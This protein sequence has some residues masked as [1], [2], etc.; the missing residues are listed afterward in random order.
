MNKR[1]ARVVRVE[2]T[3]VQAKRECASRL[4]G[5]CKRGREAR[6]VYPRVQ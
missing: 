2:W 1:N 6:R 4:F 5:T 3:K